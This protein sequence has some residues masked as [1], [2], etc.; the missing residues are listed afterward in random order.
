MYGG[1]GIGGFSKT[2]TRR[3]V[4]QGHALLFPLPLVL[5]LAEKILPSP[6]V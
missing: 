4:T 2:A 1:H 3:G 6:L 5:P